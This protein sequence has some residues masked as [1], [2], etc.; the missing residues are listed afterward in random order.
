MKPTWYI[1]ENNGISCTIRDAADHDEDGDGMVCEQATPDDARLIAASP[2]LLAALLNLTSSLEDDHQLCAW[3]EDMEWE[4]RDDMPHHV[5]CVA[6]KARAAIDKANGTAFSCVDGDHG[7]YSADQ[8]CGCPC[9]NC[10]DETELRCK[11]CNT[12]V[13]SIRN[14]TFYLAST[15][16]PTETVP[17]HCEDCTHEF[18]PDNG[19]CHDCGTERPDWG[20]RTNCSRC[21]AGLDW[22]CVAEHQCNTPQA[23]RKP[24]VHTYEQ[25]PGGE[26]RMDANCGAYVCLDC[27]DHDGLARCY[28]GWASDGGDGV[29]QLRAEGENVEDDY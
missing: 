15:D 20:S 3:G 12:I 23:K 25:K 11:V 17:D 7:C 1:A 10:H 9:D 18:D 28:C 16:A 22:N 2:D 24:H 13:A 14:S 19:P 5:D 21:G 4:Q 29:A 8:P 27:N 6:G 26:R